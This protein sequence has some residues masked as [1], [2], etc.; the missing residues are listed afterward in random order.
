MAEYSNA[1]GVDIAVA[2]HS[3]PSAMTEN[4]VFRCMLTLTSVFMAGGT[5]MHTT[6]HD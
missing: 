6:Y 2:E 1:I 4:V 3:K 5:R